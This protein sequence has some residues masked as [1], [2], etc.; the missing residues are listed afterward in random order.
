MKYDQFLNAIHRL[1][2]RQLTDE[3]TFREQQKAAQELVDYTSDYNNHATI[4]EVIYKFNL[5]ARLFSKFSENNYFTTKGLLIAANLSRNP[6]THNVLIDNKIDRLLIRFL[7]SSD[8]SIILKSYAAIILLH[9]CIGNNTNTTMPSICRIPQLKDLLLTLSELTKNAETHSIIREIGGIEA[10]WRLFC[11]NHQTIHSCVLINLIHLSENTD[12]IKKMQTIENTHYLHALS[13]S[14]HFSELPLKEYVSILLDRITKNTRI[15]DFR[16]YLPPMAIHLFNHLSREL[17]KKQCECYIVGSSIRSIC[18]KK[19]PRPGQDID[20]L[21]TWPADDNGIIQSD[22][23][24]FLAQK[25]FSKSPYL[26]NLYKQQI[27]HHGQAYTMDCFVK[28]QFTPGKERKIFNHINDSY[29]ERDVTQK[30]LYLRF[31]GLCFDPTGLG[32]QDLQNK[33]LRAVIY[34]EISLMVDPIRLLSAIKSHVCN[35]DTFD[36]NLKKAMGK[37]KPK[38]NGLTHNERSHCY[39]YTRTQLLKPETRQSFFNCL[40]KFDLLSKLFSIFIKIIDQATEIEA[41]N[42]LG[43]KVN[44]DNRDGCDY[45]KVP[46]QKLALLSDATIEEAENVTVIDKK[47]AVVEIIPEE[48]NNPIEK[49]DNVSSELLTTVSDETKKTADAN[50]SLSGN[51]KKTSTVD[52]IFSSFKK[53]HQLTFQSIIQPSKEDSKPDVKK[54][55]KAANLL[56]KEEKAKEEGKRMAEEDKR[57]AEK[58][59]ALKAANDLLYMAEVSDKNWEKK[60]PAALEEYKKT[61]EEYQIDV[62]KQS[63]YIKLQEKL[64]EKIAS[65]KIQESVK[66]AKEE[67]VISLPI[68]VENSTEFHANEMNNDISLQE[69]NTILENT[70]SSVDISDIKNLSVTEESSSE[71]E[72]EES[73]KTSKKKKTKKKT[74][75]EKL[76][77]I[78]SI[79]GNGSAILKELTEAV[80]KCSALM[81]KAKNTYQTAI[82]LER[83]ILNAR[84]SFYSHQ[85]SRNTFGNEELNTTYQDNALS[86]LRM[87]RET[88]RTPEVFYWIGKVFYTNF[89]RMQYTLSHAD[90]MLPA[91]REQTELGIDLVYRSAYDNFSNM[92][93]SSNADTVLSPTC[94]AEV[95]VKIAQF[96]AFFG[97]YDKAI[98]HYQS[99]LALNLEEFKSVRFDIAE[100]YGNMGH[101]SEAIKTFQSILD[102]PTFDF[103]QYSK[104]K[105]YYNL[106]LI[107]QK[108]NDHLQAIEY[109]KLARKNLT[110][111]YDLTTYPL[112]LVSQKNGLFS[113]SSILSVPVLIKA[114]N[115]FYFYNTD[116]KERMD[117]GDISNIINEYGIIF[118][119]EA[120]AVVLNDFYPE[121]YR[122]IGRKNNVFIWSST[123]IRL[124]RNLEKDLCFEYGLEKKLATQNAHESYSKSGDIPEEARQ[125]LIADYHIVIEYLERSR[126]LSPYFFEPYWNLI[127]ILKIID[128][129]SSKI[130]A[131]FSKAMEISPSK[132][133]EAAQKKAASPSTAPKL[134]S[135]INTPKNTVS[136]AGNP[137]AFKFSSDNN[138]NNTSTHLLEEINKNNPLPPPVP[139]FEGPC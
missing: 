101:Y 66:K 85:S 63:L 102:D 28:P 129:T 44:I 111:F 31:D 86:D 29:K 45:Y 33:K 132:V 7:G 64:E 5:Q 123:N 99:A 79:R 95:H 18:N 24:N 92:L 72:K 48:S 93:K 68:S 21:L 73:T 115:T 107:A 35:G 40:V 105:L 134:S 78:K 82:L 58:S 69:T 43:F 60:W 4:L 26:P 76:A 74:L 6:Q 109:I 81:D 122:L 2:S 117:L 49:T 34:P 55:R 97:D 114:E 136:S 87:V 130:K 67:E 30:C 10:L 77:A 12:N 110:D 56:A 57:K 14:S 59:N 90:N 138:K 113:T 11:A 121:L 62:D 91:Q 139:K 3:L 39:A 65:I 133:R 96:H 119:L 80:E 17:L 126:E 124:L 106:A 19:S 23:D 13:K 127:E 54:Q 42:T 135:L 51:S 8:V 128:P 1:F 52:E 36:E 32:F 46:P 89:R 27:F 71:D 131:Y 125:A 37:W 84:L 83:G 108:M 98:K 41:W 53:T 15:L 137:N 103:Q 16:A 116:T 120:S 75:T 100:I 38:V 47:I 118:G 112:L 20:I 22:I 94:Y 104:A 25:G 88:L 50:K 70:N 61:V 9:L